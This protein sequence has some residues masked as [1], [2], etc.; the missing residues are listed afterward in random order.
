[1]IALVLGGLAVAVE[2]CA[3]SLPFIGRGEPEFWGFAVPWD[4]RS[5]ASARE[6]GGSLDAIVGGWIALD[7]L[8]GQPVAEP[9][10]AAADGGAPGLSSRREMAIV[11]T[12]TGNRFHPEVVRA[13]ANSDSA[14]GAAAQGV[15]RQAATA[16]YRGLVLDFEGHGPRDR[17]VLVKVVQAI[18]DS[19][20]AHGL[21]PVA[22]A[23]PAGDTASY[24]ARPLLPGADLILVMLYDEHWAGSRPG[25]VAS[26]DW[27]RRQL[28]VRVGEV[29]ADRLVVSLPLH[30]Y[31]WRPNAAT[32][33]VS[34]AEARGL[35]A[36]AGGFL[37][38]EP[39]SRTLR[40]ARAGEWEVWVSDAELVRALIA[41]ARRS[42]VRRFALWRLG[43]EDPAVWGAM[44]GR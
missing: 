18:G 19:A 10:T 39:A 15:A 5:D 34:F 6:H 42:N 35:A 13:L 22:V 8:T 32:Q 21:G 28:G 17:N 20:R 4:P 3:S 14:L 36:E 41:E 25:S 1:V 29:G 7:T 24:P 33:V 40:A 27:A 2:G 11:T 26:P 38:R 12:F 44:D 30:G 23:V 31:V 37:E 43:L 9:G 16:G